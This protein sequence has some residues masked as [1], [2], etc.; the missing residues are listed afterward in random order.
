[1]L[2]HEVDYGLRVLVA[3]GPHES[4][5]VLRIIEDEVEPGGD[6]GLIFYFREL[7]WRIG[8]AHD[9]A[10]PGQGTSLDLY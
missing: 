3:W 4:K 6:I 1:M 10:E 5:V 9:R 7:R 8:H 2:P